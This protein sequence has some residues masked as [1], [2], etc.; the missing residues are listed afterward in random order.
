MCGT[1]DQ[2]AE[3]KKVKERQ[4]Q[5][6]RPGSYDVVLHSPEIAHPSF[7]D[8]PLLFHGEDGFPETPIVLHNLDLITQFTGAFLD[9][10]LLSE[11]QTLFDGRTSPVP[12]AIV[13]A[14][15]H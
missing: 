12:E 7:S 2:I 15:G 13:T 14:Y 1:P 3:Y 5:Q 11:K 4:L 6:L 10:T 8:M 9:K